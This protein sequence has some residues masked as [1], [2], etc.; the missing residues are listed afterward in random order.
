MGQC[1]LSHNQMRLWLLNLPSENN[2]IAC[3]CHADG[4]YAEPKEEYRQ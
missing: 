2:S 4:L 1:D 3:N